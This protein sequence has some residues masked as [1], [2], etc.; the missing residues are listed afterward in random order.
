MAYWLQQEQGCAVT[1]DEIHQASTQQR[2][3]LNKGLLRQH[4]IKQIII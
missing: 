3:L 1:R 4:N 2:K